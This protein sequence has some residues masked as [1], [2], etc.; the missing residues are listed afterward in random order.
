MS[1]AVQRV[2]SA[3]SLPDAA[4]LAAYLQGRVAG[5]GGAVAIEPLGGGQSNPTFLLS[6]GARRYALRTKPGRV[7]ELLPSAHQIEREFR[8]LAALEGSGV[9]VPRV[10]LLCTDEDVIGRAFYLM[11]YVDGRVF[12]DPRLPELTNAERGAL[13]ADMNRVLAHLHGL[14]YRALGL[15][16]YGKPGDY[17]ARQ[18]ARWSKQYRASETETIEAMDRLIEWLPGQLPADDSTTLVHGDFRLDNLVIDAREPKVVGVLDWELST[19]GSPLAD[20]SYHCCV[21]HFPAGRHRGLGT[22]DLAALGLPSEAE[23][24]AAYCRNT[25]RAGI[26]H[27]DYYLA[28]NF[29]RMAAIVQGI[30]K[31]AE[32]GTAAAANALEMGRG[33]RLLAEMGWERA[34]RIRAG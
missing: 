33:A 34:Q 1:D 19:L 23:Y 4:R 30:R 20:F 27:W 8:V 24:V 31:R 32:Q 9:P 17:L 10:H 15:G 2:R 18:I 11:D 13:F 26:G 7:A 6:A 12:Q 14:D 16:D 3:A 28:Y 21:F 5:L 29:F 25:G 22:A